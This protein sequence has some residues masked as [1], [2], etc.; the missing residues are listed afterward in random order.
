LREINVVLAGSNQNSKAVLAGTIS[1]ASHADLYVTGNGYLELTANNSYA[2][3]TF[4]M[5][6]RLRI[7]N[8]GTTGSLGTG[9]RIENRSELEINRSGTLTI[10]QE[11][12]GTGKLF[13]TGPGTIT[14]TASNGGSGGTFVSNGRLVVNNTSGPGLNF[15]A[16]V[17]AGILDGIGRVNNGLGIGGT[18]RLTAGTGGSAA[19]RRLDV[20][21][22]VTFSDTSSFVVQLFATDQ[23]SRVHSTSYFTIG[24]TARLR[25]ELAGV[26]VDQFR[27]AGPRQFVV[28]SSDSTIGGGF[29]STDFTTAGFQPGE[30]TLIPT[31]NQLV[32]DFAPVPEPATVGAI[33][34]S[35]LGLFALRRTRG[36]LRQCPA[37]ELVDD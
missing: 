35:L 6:G 7:G 1:G 37:V 11:I 25:L 30:W 24:N 16:S 13:I 26:T 17:S 15:G 20:T 3:S 22:P 36:R 12:S 34:W 32:L 28:L 4:I 8:G 9:G 31:S 23:L 27:G 19:D 29:G 10:V 2:G 21:G 18:G 33:A 14:L 5:G